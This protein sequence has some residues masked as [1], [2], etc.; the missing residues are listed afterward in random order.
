VS[1]VVCVFLTPT[2]LLPTN[3]HLVLPRVST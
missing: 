1:L 3:F 2:L